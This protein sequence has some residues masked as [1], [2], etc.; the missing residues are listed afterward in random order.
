MKYTTYAREGDLFCIDDQ[1]LMRQMLLIFAAPFLL[2]G[3]GVLAN[4]LYRWLFTS[5]PVPG[6]MVVFAL[7]PL[8]F[9]SFLISF[10]FTRYLSTDGRYMVT[11]HRMLFFSWED[12]QPL[13][14]FSKIQ[15]KWTLVHSGGS[16]KSN[17]RMVGVVLDTRYA[18]TE[19]SADSEYEIAR[20]KAE[21]LVKSFNKPLEDL[22]SAEPV[23][24][25][26]EDIDRKLVLTQTDMPEPPENCAI[27][28]AN[29][30]QGLRFTMPC[31]EGLPFGGIFRMI[32]LVIGG[33][34]MQ[35]RLGGSVPHGFV[36]GFNIALYLAVIFNVIQAFYPY[37]FR[38]WIEVSKQGVRAK[39]SAFKK[40]V[41]LR[42]SG[43][44]EARVSKNKIILRAD[45]FYAAIPVNSSPQDA[46]FMLQIIRWLATIQSR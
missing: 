22:T 7:F 33:L 26:P 34:Y 1:R 13:A 17:K 32:V 40:P 14:S 36:V 31:R 4:V 15:L 23:I 6:G 37:Y 9:G 25:A 10:R 29:T 11:R 3:A 12:K 42:L 19:L 16:N 44:E 35:S 8:L 41:D 43:L 39:L 18:E 28:L 27:R 20:S 46:E 21:Q 45:G 5:E 24:T 2:A 38:P 30:E